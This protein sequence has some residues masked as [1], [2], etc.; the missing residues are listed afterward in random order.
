MTGLLISILALNVLIISFVYKKNDFIKHILRE[1]LKLT[2]FA[3]ILNYLISL[4]LEAALTQEGNRKC[5]CRP[6]AL[7]KPS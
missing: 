4:V 1:V 2:Y 5:Y 7:R 3:H 6:R